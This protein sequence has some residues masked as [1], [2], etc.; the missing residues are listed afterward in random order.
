MLLYPLLKKLLAHIPLWTGLAGVLPALSAML[1]HS[2]PL[3]RWVS[4]GS[5]LALP[6]ALYSTDCF[7]VGLPRPALVSAIITLCSPWFCLFLAGIFLLPA[8]KPAVAR[9]FLPTALPFFR[10]W[11]ATTLYIYLP[12]SADHL[13]CWPDI[14][15]F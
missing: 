5:R 3:I 14:L 15:G 9:F 10:W 12:A 7:L 8:L 13:C 1:P 6:E 11:D 2:P 4:W